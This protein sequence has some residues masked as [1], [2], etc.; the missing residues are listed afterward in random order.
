MTISSRPIWDLS[1]KD[2]N[3][4][5]IL[6]VEIKSKTGVSTDWA[7]R[8]RQNIL[9]R[10]TSSKAPYFLLIFPDNLYLW[11]NDGDANADRDEPAYVASADSIIRPY[12]E[13]VST[14]P[15][16]LSEKSL[17]LIVASWLSEILPSE[18]YPERIDDSQDWLLDSG[19]YDAL[20]G[21]RL[22]FQAVA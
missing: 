2:Q 3:D 18:N 13:R 14:R 10:D 19:L 16:Q 15:R 21:G 6:V 17:E 9:A 7:T 11:T 12:F 1:V 5:L 22:E 8:F 4:Q 20:T